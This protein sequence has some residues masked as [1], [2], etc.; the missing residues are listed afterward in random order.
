MSLLN[1]PAIRLEQTLARTIQRTQQVADPAVPVDPLR[2]AA[3]E[4]SLILT[5]HYESM[6]A[7]IA[8]AVEVVDAEPVTSMRLAALEALLEMIPTP[9]G[10]V[11]A[12]MPPISLAT[13]RAVAALLH[14]DDSLVQHR[15]FVL[16]QRLR[17]APPTLYKEAEVLDMG[18]LGR[19]LL[20]CVYTIIRSAPC[21]IVVKKVMSTHGQT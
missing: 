14:G 5:M 21:S 12:P 13:L 16:L 10:R 20:F 6:D 7:A 9:S 1:Q 2:R 4:C 17:G 19:C 18:A 15:A 3:L 11:A 8:R